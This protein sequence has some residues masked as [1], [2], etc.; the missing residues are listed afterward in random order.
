MKNL[1]VVLVGMSLMGG[2]GL[3]SAGG[4]YD[5]QEWSAIRA[6]KDL[7]VQSPAVALHFGNVFNMCLDG[8]TFRSIKPVKYCT[9]LEALQVAAQGDIDV[10]RTEYVCSTVNTIEGPVAKNL[11]HNEE[12]CTELNPDYTSE[13][14]GDF[15]K[16]SVTERRDYPTHFDLHIYRNWGGSI[17]FQFDGSKNW[18]IPPCSK[19]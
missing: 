17:G 10:A 19:N 4:F 11:T 3:A 8:T 1:T 13:A 16:T 14:G 2:A 6:R 12:I 9:E 18:G 7:R 5:S 15:C